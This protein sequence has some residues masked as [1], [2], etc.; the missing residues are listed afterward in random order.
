MEPL[1]HPEGVTIDQPYPC[2]GQP[3][4]PLWPPAPVRTAAKFMHAG[5]IGTAAGLIAELAVSW[6]DHACH[7]TLLGHHYTTPTQPPVGGQGSTAVAGGGGVDNAGG[8]ACCCRWVQLRQAACRA[9]A[10]QAARRATARQVA[11]RAA[12]RAGHRLPGARTTLLCAAAVPGGLW[13]AATG[14][15]RIRRPGTDGG[16]HREAPALL[17]AAFTNDIRQDLARCDREFHLRAA[18]LQVINNLAKAALPWQAG[19]EEI[20]DVEIVHAGPG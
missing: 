14:E 3:A 17:E 7:L 19:S 6:D 10:R 18:P 5:A 4:R 1:A 11:R 2:T 15:S 16:A 13:R 8:P 9:T 20:E 12:A